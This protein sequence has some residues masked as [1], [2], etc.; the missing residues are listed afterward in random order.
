MEDWGVTFLE[1]CKVASQSKDVTIFIKSEQF[2][3]LFGIL[4][5]IPLPV[6]VKLGKSNPRWLQ[7]YVQV[8]RDGVEAQNELI[9]HLQHHLEQMEELMD[10]T[11]SPVWTKMEA[12]LKSEDYQI[13]FKR[14]E[15]N[16]RQMMCL[17]EE[18]DTMRAQLSTTVT[19][20]D[21]FWRIHGG[22]PE[23]SGKEDGAGEKD[24][25]R[26]LLDTDQGGVKLSRTGFRSVRDAITF[27]INEAK[28][29]GFDY[30]DDDEHKES[31]SLASAAMGFGSPGDRQNLLAGESSETHGNGSEGEDGEEWGESGWDDEIGEYWNYDAETGYYQYYDEEGNICEYW[32]EEPIYREPEP[33]IDDRDEEIKSK[34]EKRKNVIS[35]LDANHPLG[36]PLKRADEILKIDDP[37]E[38]N[39]DRLINQFDDNEEFTKI[40]DEN[41]P[42]MTS[43]SMGTDALKQTVGIVK[44]RNK[45]KMTRRSKLMIGLGCIMLFCTSIMTWQWYRIGSFHVLQIAQE[46]SLGFTATN[47]R[48]EV[49]SHLG[50]TKALASS[51]GA[52][53]ESNR[54]VG[55]DNVNTQGGTTFGI[56]SIVMGYSM[57][58]AFNYRVTVATSLGAV[59]SAVRVGQNATSI[60]SYRIEAQD[61]SPKNCY[62]TYQLRSDGVTERDTTKVENTDCGFD[63]RQRSWYQDALSSNGLIWG[64]MSAEPVGLVLPLSRSLKDSTGQIIGVVCI[65]VEMAK[66]STL[67][68]KL[69]DNEATKAFVLEAM[70]PPLIAASAAPE[71]MYE[72]T[73]H[74]PRLRTSCEDVDTCQLKTPELQIAV[75]ELID[76]ASASGN[77]TA[78]FMNFPGYNDIT[79]QQSSLYL[80]ASRLS[81]DSNLNLILGVTMGRSDVL[82]P[83]TRSIRLSF[84]LVMLIVVLSVLSVAAFTLY[85]KDDKKKKQKAPEPA[86]TAKLAREASRVSMASSIGNNAKLRGDIK[87]VIL[88]ICLIVGGY[89]L[90]WLLWYDVVSTAVNKLLMSNY[91]DDVST[92]GISGLESAIAHPVRL[93]KKSKIMLESTRVQLSTTT[94]NKDSELEYLLHGFLSSTPELTSLSVV[95]GGGHFL[96]I[97]RGSTDPA[98]MFLRVRDGSTSNVLKEFTVVN[99]ARGTELAV[100]TD[101]KPVETA[102]YLQGQTMGAEDVQA[103]PIRADRNQKAVLTVLTP[104]HISGSYY[105]VVTGTVEIAL[106]TKLISNS[107]IEGVSTYIF[108]P[109]CGPQQSSLCPVQGPYMVTSIGSSD[110]LSSGTRI[111]AT[112]MIPGMIGKLKSE[113]GSLDKINMGSEKD[114]LR[115]E[116]DGYFVQI[117]PIGGLLKNL[118]WMAASGI[119]VDQVRAD[120][121]KDVVG[122]IVMLSLFT[123]GSIAALLF[124]ITK[125]GKKL[126]KQIASQGKAKESTEADVVLSKAQRTTLA[127]LYVDDAKYGRPYHIHRGDIWYVRLYKLWASKPYRKLM[128]VVV[129]MHSFLAIFESVSQMNELEP[130]KKSQVAGL[131]AANILICFVYAADVLLMRFLLT[132]K[133]FWKSHVA[134]VQVFLICFFFLDSLVFAAGGS[135]VRVSRPLRPCMLILLSTNLRRLVALLFS[136]LPSLFDVVILLACMMFIFG[137]IGVLS[138]A[139]MYDYGPGDLAQ[140]DFENF[141]NA[142]LTLYVLM[143]ADNYP[144]IMIPTLGKSDM[145]TVYFITWLVIGYIGFVALIVVKFNNGYKLHR[146]AENA[147]EQVRQRKCLVSAFN[148]LDIDGSRSIDLH[149]FSL[150]F[151]ND[152]TI[153]SSEVETRFKDV[154]VDGSGY[155]DLFEFFDLCDALIISHEPVYDLPNPRPIN[156]F[157]RSIIASDIFHWSMLLICVTHMGI[158]ALYGSV[159]NKDALDSC[160]YVIVFWYVVELGWKWLAWGWKKLWYDSTFNKFDVS[161]VVSSLTGLCFA[162]MFY[163]GDNTTWRLLFVIPAFR[164]VTVIRPTRKLVGTIF[165]IIPP[166][167]NIMTVFLVIGYAY[168][169]IGM[170]LYAT[171]FRFL[172][173]DLKKH[174]NFDDF[175]SG[176]RAL[177]QLFSAAAWGDIMWAAI[178]TTSLFSVFFFLSFQFICVLMVNLFV[179]LVIDA[180][181][182][183]IEREKQ[184]DAE[185]EKLREEQLKLKDEV[186]VKNR[187]DLVFK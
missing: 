159:E 25:R 54:I 4:Q 35:L 21:V 105:G 123:V 78:Y 6:L 130:Q 103:M 178:T 152:N 94:F 107:G 164:C 119:S 36:E 146:Q 60:G 9:R 47:L 182:V 62:R 82:F 96:E 91:L 127:L 129:L 61:G 99:A 11:P 76:S 185:R 157:F 175:A 73:S 15:E 101:I 106:L 183:E 43:A 13:R 14:E 161:I 34:R 181:N 186:D 12:S 81:D 145:P 37:D 150:L 88:K 66:I 56:D 163:D 104:L 74:G 168:A 30:T 32:P 55:I 128:N 79:Q 93:V 95:T 187:R 18:E 63:P 147:R 31:H 57:A 176:V 172:D 24:P 17:S 84:S 174:I 1:T 160:N 102:E 58:D 121:Q 156:F 131:H 83:I 109:S 42:V 162:W 151:E 26:H 166:F 153:T 44:S 134:K 118:N 169:V 170:E 49:S 115:F 86:P 173:P 53:I 112:D 142:A 143:S 69:F 28:D 140:Y 144:D 27:D 135:I 65:H 20:S 148:L 77:S 165:K 50:E 7:L 177:L 133:V 59:V 87:T 10:L 68:K 19:S 40:M 114:Y 23:D 22:A 85:M 48:T 71:E 100:P 154:D 33:E 46:D 92:R 5:L 149:E 111:K 98:A 29:D 51:F 2:R 8:F 52:T 116:V 167:S 117:H 3:K 108:E 39:I 72:T 180:F 97:Y 16:R 113:F 120:F 67:M 158:L 41:K 75:T 179:S 141:Q 80:T 132:S 139:G 171:S 70:D 38:S 124:Y 122:M 137:V 136:T 126:K 155:V 184:E 45:S 110:D 90:L 138:F 125:V 64:K 89:L